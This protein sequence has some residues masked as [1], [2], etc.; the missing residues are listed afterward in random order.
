MQTII[1]YIAVRL[2]YLI[3]LYYILFF[4]MNLSLTQFTIIVSCSLILPSINNLERSTSIVFPTNL[5]SGL[6]P[7]FISY[8]SFI[9]SSR[10]L[11]VNSILILKSLSLNS[12]SLIILS[13]IL[14]IASFV[15]ALNTTISSIRFINSGLNSFSI[16]P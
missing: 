3:F 12:I 6:A 15:K 1:Y 10:A 14:L 13:N 4:T 2:F 5:F 7:K 16:L 9:N 11:S 8:P